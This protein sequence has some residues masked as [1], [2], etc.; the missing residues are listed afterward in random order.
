V[1]PRKI[2]HKKKISAINQ[3]FFLLR[4]CAVPGKA[5]PVLCPPLVRGR[6]HLTAA[7]HRKVGAAGVGNWIGK[8]TGNRLKNVTAARISPLSFSRFFKNASAAIPPKK[9]QDKKN[10]VFSV[11]AKCG[12]K[13]SLYATMI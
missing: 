5:P 9:K 4:K 11:F 2:F 6:L 7:L 8:N 10:R 1:P 3:A 12:N 13:I